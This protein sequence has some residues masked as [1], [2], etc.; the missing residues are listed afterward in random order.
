[1]TLS[2]EADNQD[3]TQPIE[4]LST[5]NSQN[6]TGKNFIAA[7]F[8]AEGS[9]Q[10]T[11][12]Q[13]N[14]NQL[15]EM[16]EERERQKAEL[17]ILQKAIA[18]KY[19]DLNR[20]VDTLAPALGNPYLF[21][22]PFG[23][24][25][26][27]RFFGRD[28]EI[29]ELCE[30]VTYRAITFLSGN[31]GVGKTSLLKAGLTPALLKQKHLPLMISV[32]NEPLEASLKKELLPN[33]DGM[34][35]LKTIS[36]TEFIRMVTSALPDGKMLIVLVDDFE[37]FFNDKEHSESE[38]NAF[39]N[40]WQRG[41]NGATLKAHWL[42]CIP[43]NLQYLLRFFNRE[44]Q[45]NP[46]TISVSPLDHRSARAA[47]LEPAKA[48]GIQVEEEVLTSILKILG[49]NNIDPA[50][51]QLVC[52]MLAGGTGTPSHEWT[53]EYYLAQGKADGI[54]RDYLDR[55]IEELEP[56]EREP[57]WQVLAVLAD[58][59][60]QTS[61]EEQLVEKLKLYDVEE[62][63]THR[64]LID[65][66]SSNLIER[67][68][69]FKLTSDSLVPRIEKWKEM[70]SA[71]ERAREEAIEQW[72]RIRNSALRGLVGGVV[73]FIAFDQT[74]YQKSLTDFIYIFFKILFDAAVGALP[75][76]VLVFS[77][78]VAVAS[79]SGSRRWLAYLGGALGGALALSCALVPYSFLLNL[80][81]GKTLGEIIASA[82]LEGGLW[83][84]AAG[85]GTVWAMKS[86]RSYWITIPVCILISGL[87]LI[88]TNS[89]FEV[90]KDP[91]LI[92]K[93]VVL[94]GLAGAALPGFIL[95]AAMIGR[96]KLH[97][98]GDSQ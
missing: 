63:I 44:A 87:T 34:P 88:A 5:G 36:L 89:I 37:E 29:A 49:G 21:L 97:W 26:R 22:Q 60:M 58:P 7:T 47:I 14:Y 81:K 85:I 3:G 53:M 48:R 72:H 68:A 78:D 46:N 52:Y 83:G 57:A 40:E 91:L 31:S 51:L 33:I 90:L 28:N 74:I 69:A 43:S 92:T 82:I 55:T 24:S 76:L 6:I 39:Y 9:A 25:D 2:P 93:S 95:V 4:P 66:E 73:G 12:S 84:A 15:S 20:L 65:L 71:R 45:T 50:A 38:R 17:D 11:I 79:Y 13:I 54:L 94:I 98:S 61:T 27:A 30:R 64:V 32:N 77:V 67:G 96:R 42:F 23:F 86:Q 1:M 41:F 35:F 70:R 19:L 18:Q 75:G 62:N 80:N 56:R 16:E 59:A 10:V 8:N